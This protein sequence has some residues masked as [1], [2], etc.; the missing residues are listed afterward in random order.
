MKVRRVKDGAA[1]DYTASSAV[2][3]GD[4][5]VIDEIAGVAS[6]DAAAG[7]KFGL[8]VSGIFDVKCGSTTFSAGDKVYWGGTTADTSP[9]SSGWDGYIGVAVEDCVAADVHVR[10]LWQAAGSETATANVSGGGLSGGLPT[11]GIGGGGGK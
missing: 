6:C 5:V 3:A 4:I 1:I 10:V 8:S 11:G 2:S 9:V 7:R